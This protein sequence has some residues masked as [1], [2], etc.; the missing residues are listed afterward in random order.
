MGCAG[1]ES[2]FGTDGWMDWVGGRTAGGQTAVPELV[3][4]SPLELDR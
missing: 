2:S 3:A 1:L 4:R